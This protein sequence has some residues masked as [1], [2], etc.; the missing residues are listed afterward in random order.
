MTLRQQVQA[1]HKA[2]GAHGPASPI[3]PRD[4]VVRHR[5]KMAAEE[6][7][8]L[9]EA[10]IEKQPSSNYVTWRV[11]AL[12]RELLVHLCRVPL[13]V[14]LVEVADALADLDYV[15]EGTRLEFGIDGGPI[16]SM[17]HSTNMAKVSAGKDARGKQL[18]GPGW[19]PPDIAGELRRQG[20][21]E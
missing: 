21:V 9:V 15:N 8:E 12:L 5:V 19:V 11:V 14:D 1:F 3:V 16:A 18:K 13:D 20:W 17:V 10:V 2:I 6:F 7:S 4:A